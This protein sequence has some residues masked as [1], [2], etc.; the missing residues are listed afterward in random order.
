MSSGIA[1]HPAYYKLPDGSKQ[2]TAYV[3]T[4]ITRKVGPLDLVDALGSKYFRHEGMED[5]ERPSDRP[6]GLPEALTQRQLLT[7]YRDEL[8]FYGEDRLPMW[9][10]EMGSRRREA[11]DRWLREIVDNAFP[12]FRGLER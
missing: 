10:D 8:L 3:V 6:K 2:D 9:A 12:E 11:C 4:T 5:D 1:V 7:L